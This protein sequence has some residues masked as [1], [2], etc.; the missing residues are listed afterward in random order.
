MDTRFQDLKAIMSAEVHR[1]E[2]VMDA[3]L[4]HLEDLAS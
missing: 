2:E 3:R 1:V 4:K